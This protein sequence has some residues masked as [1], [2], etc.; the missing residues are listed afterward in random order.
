MFFYMK[1]TG[2]RDADVV[3]SCYRTVQLLKRSHLILTSQVL[4]NIIALSVQST[5]CYLSFHFF[6]RFQI[7]DGHGIEHIDFGY[8]D[9]LS[10]ILLFNHTGEVKFISGDV[11]P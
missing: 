6:I 1:V 2:E 8:L 5:F 10:Q 4:H 11:K 9:T 3:R 7:Y